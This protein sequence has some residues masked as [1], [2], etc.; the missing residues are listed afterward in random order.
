MTREDEG[1][2]LGSDELENE[3][4]EM[5]DEQYAMTGIVA[6]SEREGKERLMECL[7]G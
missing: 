5:G 3:N 6:C 2:N 7:E 4:K 1:R